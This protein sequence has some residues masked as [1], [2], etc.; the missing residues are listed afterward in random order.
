[1]RKMQEAY[2]RAD[3]ISAEVKRKEQE[4]QKKVA[5]E[6]EDILKLI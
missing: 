4:E 5:W 6:T 1:M 3:E 2:N